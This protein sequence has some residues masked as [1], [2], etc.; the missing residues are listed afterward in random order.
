MAAAK[1]VTLA[2]F[3][4]WLRQQPQAIQGA[5]VRGLRSAAHR[6]VGIVVQ[7]IDNAE[8]Y[9]AVDTGGMRQSVHVQNHPDGAEIYVDA[10]HAGPINNGTRP[11]RPPVSALVTWAVRKGL[12]AN[13]QEAWPIAKAVCDKIEA[14]GIEPRHFWEKAMARMEEVIRGEVQYELD[15][16]GA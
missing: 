11:F 5:V 3:Q 15:K 10:P 8:P 13:E 4:K 9:P 6:G 14:E 7:E 1:Q 12:A 2:Q 16:I